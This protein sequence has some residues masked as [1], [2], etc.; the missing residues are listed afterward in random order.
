[1]RV[2]VLGHIAAHSIGTV[3]LERLGFMKGSLPT[4]DLV[5]YPFS[6]PIES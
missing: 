6:A 5:S 1:L 4:E 2:F 3:M